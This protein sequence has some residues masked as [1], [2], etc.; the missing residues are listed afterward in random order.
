MNTV[1]Y[2]DKQRYAE[3]QPPENK[4]KGFLTSDFSRR[5]EFSKDFATNQYRERLKMEAKYTNKAIGSS[6]ELKATLQAELGLDGDDEQAAPASPASPG[7][8]KKLLYDLVFDNGSAPAVKHSMRAGRD[9]NN[10]T[11]LS[12]KRDFGTLRLSSQDVGYGTTGEEGIAILQATLRSR[13]TK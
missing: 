9:T 8:R 2:V 7:G 6:K 4:K 13:A 11:Q 3:S 12:W 5:D 10:P 1:P